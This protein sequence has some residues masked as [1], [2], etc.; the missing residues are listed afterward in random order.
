MR[1]GGK[2]FRVRIDTCKMPG[3]QLTTRCTTLGRQIFPAIHK[4]SL[5]GGMN[6][7]SFPL[8]VP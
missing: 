4:F 5:R 8:K 2:I 1:S 7:F 3:L 6:Q